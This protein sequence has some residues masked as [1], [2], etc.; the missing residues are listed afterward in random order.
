MTKKE[1][2][3]EAE[4]KARR[5]ERINAKFLERVRKAGNV[6]KTMSPSGGNNGS[7]FSFPDGK[8]AAD[9]IV[10]RLIQNGSL[11]ATGDG[12]FGDSQTYVPS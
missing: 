7:Y 1:L 3:S 2:M 4:K 12:L 6:T 8:I 5:E 10:H 11:R 9:H